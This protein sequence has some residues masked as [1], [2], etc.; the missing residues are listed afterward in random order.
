MFIRSRLALGFLAVSALCVPLRGALAS[1]SASP[2][3]QVEIESASGRPELTLRAQASVSVLQDTVTMVFARN[4]QGKAA[5]EVNQQLAQSIDQARRLVSDGSAVKVSSG[6]FRVT[7]M[8]GKDGKINGWQ[9][10]AEL[11]LV[12]TD[13]PAIATLSTRMAEQLELASVYFSLSDQA[14]QVEEARLLDQVAI[15]FRDRAQ[16]AATAFGFAQYTV[17]RLDL[18][19][20][21]AAPQA[22]M[23]APMVMRAVAGADAAPRVDVPLVPDRVNVSASVSGTVYLR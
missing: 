17:K 10:H 20:A 22:P 16:R 1:D 14:R 11:T 2:A 15:A 23:P 13:F 3:V 19:G 12:S 7:P 6:P 8:F 4:V 21:G 18:G 9:G 5:S